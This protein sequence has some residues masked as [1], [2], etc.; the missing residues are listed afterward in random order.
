MPIKMGNNP[1]QEDWSFGDIS[2]TLPSKSQINK[3]MTR[4]SNFDLEM[5]WQ[6][7]IKRFGLSKERPENNKR[8]AKRIWGIDQFRLKYYLGQH[9]ELM[10]EAYL[11]ELNI[12]KEIGDKLLHIETHLFKER[13]PIFQDEH[14]FNAKILPFENYHEFYQCAE[15][16]E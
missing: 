11:H 5:L 14:H 7:A 3:P 12:L 16:W 1:Q 2:S 9:D 15:P 13:S 10:I 4:M 8:R 6:E